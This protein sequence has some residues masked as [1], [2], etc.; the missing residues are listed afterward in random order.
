LEWRFLQDFN[1]HSRDISISHPVT[2]RLNEQCSMTPSLSVQSLEET[3][4]EGHV[5]HWYE[6][7]MKARML[8]E[9]AIAEYDGELDDAI[10]AGKRE[11][12]IQMQQSEGSEAQKKL[13]SMC[14]SLRASEAFFSVRKT[15]ASQ[16]GVHSIVGFV[17][18]RKSPSPRDFL[19]SLETGLMVSRGFVSAVCMDAGEEESGL[20]LGS[21]A[22]AP[23]RLTGAVKQLFSSSWLQGVVRTS[24]GNTLIS[25]VSKNSHMEVG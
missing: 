11:A 25:L 17:M 10:A 7:M 22:S 5:G 6:L 3:L 8:A 18:H 19:F 12:F 20:S 21:D 13:Q 2:L 16:L 9:G 15:L 14:A 23:F 4:C 24:M 1:G